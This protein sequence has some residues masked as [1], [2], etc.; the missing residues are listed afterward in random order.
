[1]LFSSVDS[2]LTWAYNLE[3]VPVCPRSNIFEG[4]QRRRT[5]RL[6]DGWTNWERHAQAALVRAQVE[7]LGDPLGAYGVALYAPLDRR[8]PAART[9]LR[10]VCPD[11]QYLEAYEL[12]VEQYVLGSS[13]AGAGGINAIRQRLCC[14]KASALQYR[15]EVFARLDGLRGQLFDRLEPVLID[16]DLIRRREHDGDLYPWVAHLPGIVAEVAELA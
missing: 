2:V 13:R 14:R 6:W 16:G 3:G 4:K 11:S 5:S 7:R 9:L 15:N 8:L 10:W 1:M 12:M